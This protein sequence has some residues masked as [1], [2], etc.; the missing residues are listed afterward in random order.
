MTTTSF[1]LVTEPWIP[2]VTTT[3]YRR[4]S[5]T[6]A[7]AGAQTTT[8]A[9]GLLEDQAIHR[10][11]LAISY[12]ATGAPTPAQYP[13][14]MD[15][16][17]VLG[18]LEVTAGCFDLFD[19]TD[20]FL[21]HTGIDP[22]TVVVGAGVLD[23]TLGRERPKLTDTRTIES[24]GALSPAEAAV[25]LIV[26]QL[27]SQGGRHTGVSASLPESPASGMITFRPAGTI[28]E[29]LRWARIPVA[30]VGESHWSFTTRPGA[31]GVAPE[32]ELDALT[33]MSRAMLLEGDA[34]GVTG[35]RTASGWRR[36]PED[37]VESFDAAAG[38]HDMAVAASDAKKPA[39]AAIFD[40][41]SGHRLAA[42]DP[43][44]LVI[45]WERGGEGSLA[46]AVRT[47]L[48]EDPSLSA[49]RIVATGQQLD[50]SLWK[51]TWVT[52]IP[53]VS[54]GF[55]ARAAD[56]INARFR[57]R[58]YGRHQRS[59]ADKTGAH[60]LGA[61]LE[62]EPGSDE[63]VQ[64]LVEALR[65]APAEEDGQ[66]RQWPVNATTLW[67]KATQEKAPDPLVTALAELPE[68]AGIPME[69]FA[70]DYKRHDLDP[71]LSALRRMWAALRRDPDAT[72]DLARV[73]ETRIPAPGQLPVDTGMDLEDSGS[74]LWAGLLAT[75]LT[76]TPGRDGAV[77]LPTLLR[78]ASHGGTHT[79]PVAALRAITETAPKPSALRLPLLE[80][81]HLLGRDEEN[82]SWRALHHDLT[83]WDTQMRRHWRD[84]YWAKTAPTT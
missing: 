40:P 67:V 38:R 66:D 50:K 31:P 11:L 17:A 36:A 43:L 56:I 28:A 64:A 9:A 6:D 10:L 73:M 75:W 26:T 24:R 1:N 35:V 4:I 12:A 34:I 13:Q 81:L 27:Y 21:Q 39:K 15:T 61:D 82:P 77:P 72:A 55:T 7:F 84:A 60:L 69:V 14:P 16:T 42:G 54:G 22:S 41:G 65:G 70:G 78:W 29:A 30:D 74:R 32:G 76:T 5:L 46:H 63:A 79:G 19:P 58:S 68:L 59:F 47:A 3:G 62:A 18:W 8:V 25:A 51:G 20:P 44:D 45:A 83:H 53:A 71:Q 23:P 37:D 80:A 48:A 49:P 33:W 57:A 52:E 2:A